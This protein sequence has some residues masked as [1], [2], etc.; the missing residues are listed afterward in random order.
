[1]VAFGGEEG[2]VFFVLRDDEEV[3][4]AEVGG[5]RVWRGFGGV[6]FVFVFGGGSVSSRDDGSFRVTVKASSVASRNQDQD[7]DWSRTASVLVPAAMFGVVFAVACV[8]VVA[9]FVFFFFFFVFFF[10]SISRE[11]RMPFH[12][13]T[14]NNFRNRPSRLFVHRYNLFHSFFHLSRGCS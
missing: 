14:P 13:T 2:D 9:L 3:I 11:L 10:S 1:M 8:S 6:G 4:G 7:G 5:G 12:R